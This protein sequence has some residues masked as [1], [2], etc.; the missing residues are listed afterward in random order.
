[1]GFEV[2]AYEELPFHPSVIY[3]TGKGK[4]KVTAATDVG[5]AEDNGITTSLDVPFSGHVTLSGFYNRS[6]RNQDDIAGFS[7]TFLLKAPPVPE[8]VAR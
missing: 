8:K 2:D 7:L 6:I 3:S 1:M 5:N 4:K